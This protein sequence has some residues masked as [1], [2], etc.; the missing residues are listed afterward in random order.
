MKY[1]DFCYSP[2]VGPHTT[3]KPNCGVSACFVGD[4][5]F[6]VLA[7]AYSTDLFNS[8]T[9]FNF[10]PLHVDWDLGCN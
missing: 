8:N 10:Y 3:P 2:L 6:V 7:A 5:D 4:F 1:V 9:L